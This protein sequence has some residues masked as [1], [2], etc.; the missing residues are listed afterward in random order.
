M[1]LKNQFSHFPYL[2][3]KNNFESCGDLEDYN[4]NGLKNVL[5]K[6]TSRKTDLFIRLLEQRKQF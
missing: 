3:W 1:L 5:K 4:N 6:K 2:N